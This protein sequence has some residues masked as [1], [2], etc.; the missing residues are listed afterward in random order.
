MVLTFEREREQERERERVSIILQQYH[1]R[2]PHSTTHKAWC[3]MACVDLMRNLAKQSGTKQPINTSTNLLNTSCGPWRSIRHR[4]TTVLSNATIL[5]NI[6]YING[7]WRSIRH[8]PRRRG[9]GGRACRDTP[10]ASPNQATRPGQH[11]RRWCGE[12]PVYL[13]GLFSFR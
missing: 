1:L 12:Y 7:P 10:Q 4:H 11:G 13:N 6:D 5:Y 9:R 8:R 2:A 3:V